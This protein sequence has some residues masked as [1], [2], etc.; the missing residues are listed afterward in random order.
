MHTLEQKEHQG[1]RGLF[2]NPR[3]WFFSQELGMGNFP[4]KGDMLFFLTKCRAAILEA[5][6]F[7]TELEVISLFIRKVY[8][9][10]LQITFYL[11][12]H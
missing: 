7:Y 2:L 10:G 6:N 4:Q 12:S 8:L 5:L 11:A 9:E 3:E 1:E